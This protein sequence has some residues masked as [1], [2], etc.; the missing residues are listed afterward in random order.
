MN[1]PALLG[2]LSATVPWNTAKSSITPLAAPG[3]GEVGFRMLGAML[4]VFAVLFAGTWAV[5]RWRLLPGGV[6]K[7][8]RLK[9][10]ESKAIAPRQSVVVLGYEEKRFL[11]AAT[12]QGV[13]LLT[14]L[15]DG[16]NEPVPEPVAAPAGFGELLI[17]ALQQ[18][19]LR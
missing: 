6:G 13:S 3:A 16:I 12:P 18:R 17:T 8:S 14:T 10:L 5:K 15:P 2:T 4:I 9:M 19:S 7:K 11:V 1:Y